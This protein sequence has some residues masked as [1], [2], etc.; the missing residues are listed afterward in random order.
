MPRLATE[1]RQGEVE[2][3]T[4]QVQRDRAEPKKRVRG[5]KRGKGAR[6]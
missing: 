2:E 5:E 3:E 1:G 4:S 6:D